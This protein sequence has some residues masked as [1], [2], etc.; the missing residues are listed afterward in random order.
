MNTVLT[1][2]H[3]TSTVDPANTDP[4]YYAATC[5][6]PAVG[7]EFELTRATT[8]PTTRTTDEDGKVRPWSVVTGRFG[9]RAIRPDGET[10]AVFCAQGT[11]TDNETHQRKQIE[12][13]VE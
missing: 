1:T 10:A 6:A 13:E 4:A 8:P 3:D 2:T 7:L 12:R 5:T 9:L 11:R